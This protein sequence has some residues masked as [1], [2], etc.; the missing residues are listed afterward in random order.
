MK[1]LIAA[2]SIA[3]GW[4]GTLSLA[5]TNLVISS[6][7]GNGYLEVTNL[8]SNA[9]CRVEWA[10]SL[11]G[12]WLQSW[13]SVRH[14]ETTTNTSLS[15]SVPMFYRVS[16]HDAPMPTPSGMCLIDAGSFTMGNPYVTNSPH[17][18]TPTHDV[19][20]DTFFID[21]Y[22]VSKAIWDRVYAWA[23]TNGYSFVRSGTGDG[24]AYPV[25]NVNWFDCVKWCNARSQFEGLTPCYYTDASLSTIYKSGQTTLT[26]TCVQWNANGYRL[27]TEAEWEKAARGGLRG[28]HYPWP[29]SG[30]DPTNHFD[31][32]KANTRDPEKTPVG[33][34]NGSQQETNSFGQVMAGEDMANGYGLYDILGNVKEQCWDWY[35]ADW[36]SQPEA[37]NTNCRGPSSGENK[38]L[39][40]GPVG[41]NGA[42]A[43]CASR[44]RTFW[45]E[46]GQGANGVSDGLRCVRKH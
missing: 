36:Y 4:L 33:Y 3:V 2:L 23:V 20:V 24:P 27:P 41:P 34:F 30:G 9:A 39:R 8:W 46:F 6:F 44:G 29:S 12:P 16:M 37:I 35:Q 43:D 14:V 32:S 22:P 5:D 13:Q 26:D 15:V 11:D 40:G 38:V 21:R 18:E 45:T 25:H 10:A 17:T 31:A 1:K 28:H 7:H 42:W 19:F